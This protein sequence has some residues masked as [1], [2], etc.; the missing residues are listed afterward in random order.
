MSVGTP[1]LRYRRALLKLSGESLGGPRGAGFDAVTIRSALGRVKEARDA[2]AELAILVG[3]GNF[4]RGREGAELGLDRPTAD[5]VGMLAT[6]MNA[7]A[8]KA[9]LEG[10]GVPARVL[11]SMT[12]ESVC[13]VFTADRARAT[14]A[15][16]RV[17]LLGGGTGNPFFTTDTGAALR[18][19]ECGAELLLKATQVDG[20]YDSDP[21]KNPGARRF[22]RLTCAEAIRLN[23][24]VM[25]QTAFTLCRENAL[26]TLVFDATLESSLLRALRGEPVGTLVTPE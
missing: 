1:A 17:L 7:L 3:G 21:R 8:L 18:A 5:R 25:D 10:M 9:A 14:L 26:P 20:V 2:G 6:L 4:F 23:L 22:E 11:G 24:Q 12:M 15:E 16:G 13:D 19:L